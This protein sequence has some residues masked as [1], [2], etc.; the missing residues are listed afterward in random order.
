MPRLRCKVAV[1][2]EQIYVSL[3]SPTPFCSLDSALAAAGDATV[4]KT[5]LVTMF[6]NASAYPK[7]YQMVCSRACPWSARPRRLTLL[8]QRRL[9]ALSSI[10]WRHDPPFSLRRPSPFPLYG[11]QRAGGSAAVPASTGSG[12]ATQSEQRRKHT[13]QFIPGW[14]NKAPCHA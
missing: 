13:T 7:N 2:G 10:S 4:G 1:V 3:N 12:S 8:L 14:G 6:R 9:L 5:A 11:R